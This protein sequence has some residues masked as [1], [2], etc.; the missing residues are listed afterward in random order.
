[1]FIN[2]TKRTLCLYNIFWLLVTQ[3][4]I[5]TIII[6]VYVC[7]TIGCAVREQQ[8][9]KRYTTLHRKRA[10]LLV[11]LIYHHIHIISHQWRIHRWWDAS[12]AGEMW[13]IVSWRWAVTIQGTIL[14]MHVHENASRRCNYGLGPFTGLR[15]TYG[16]QYTFITSLISSPSSFVYR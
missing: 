13:G 4:I 11:Q 5:I 15:V 7:I 8:K 16:W 1:M 2:V 12:I 6:Q 14:M 3:H 9:N 10:V